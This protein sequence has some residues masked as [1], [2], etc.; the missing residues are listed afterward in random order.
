MK[1]VTRSGAKVDRV[2]CPWLIR[3]FIDPEAQFLFVPTAQ[4]LETARREGGRSFDAEGADYTHRGNDC[5]FETLI[6]EFHLEDSALQR[7]ARIVHGADIPHDINTTP[8]SAGLRALAEGL[9]QVCLDDQKKLEVMS[10]LYD[11]L[12]AYCEGS[13]P[14][15][16]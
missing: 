1:W 11:A 6:K 4:V 16:M 12:Y 7:L 2:A 15:S 5:T 13:R 10:P 14:S 9:A 3:R 8:E